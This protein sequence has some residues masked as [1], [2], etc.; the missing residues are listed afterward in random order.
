MVHW[1]R[2]A[3]SNTNSWIFAVT[4]DLDFSAL[5]DAQLVD[6]LT[7][8]VS[9]AAAAILT[10]NPATAPRRTK[11]DRSP[12]SAADESANAII[13]EQLSHL[14]GAVE[15]ID[16]RETPGKRGG[17]AIGARRFLGHDWHIRSY[18]LK[19]FVLALIR[20][21]IELLQIGF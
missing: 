11:S 9:R 17:I 13:L 4:S 7:T 5:M 3:I 16:E 15:R 1:S 6:R 2:S 19:W 8:I 10:F 20:H 12:V 21:K 18:K 14:A